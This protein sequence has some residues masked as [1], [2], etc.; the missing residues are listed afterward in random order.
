MDPQIEHIRKQ[1]KEILKGSEFPTAEIYLLK[2]TGK[3]PTP[4]TINRIFGVPVGIDD[5]S[6]PRYNEMTDL[7]IKEWD[8]DTRMDHIFTLDLRGLNI[9]NPE[10]A[11]A[12]A[13]FISDCKM[14]NAYAPFENE[15]TSSP[16]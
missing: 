14:N 10:N 11:S 16:P 15:L 13:F 7:K 3:N 8:G 5:K 2:V 6:W 12:L 4:D 9:Y 1:S